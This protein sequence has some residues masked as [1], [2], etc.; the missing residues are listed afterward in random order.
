MEMKFVVDNFKKQLDS[1]L[2]DV[3]D[4]N[5]GGGPDAQEQPEFP[6]S[7][8]LYGVDD[9]KQKMCEKSVDCLF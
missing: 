3:P 2:I 8:A 1:Y 5:Q 4:G 6:Q 7:A 9:L